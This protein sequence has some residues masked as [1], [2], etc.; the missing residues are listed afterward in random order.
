[1]AAGLL[2]ALAPATPARAGVAAHHVD[3]DRLRF[4]GGRLL[5]A[6]QV[7]SR[8][9]AIDAA[10]AGRA[11]RRL[12]LLR[13]GPAGACTGEAGNFGLDFGFDASAQALAAS[14]LCSGAGA[15]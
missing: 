10:A 14:S 7:G 4:A 3:V 8:S 1:M 12:A 9:E 13:A 11:P 15:P 6:D 2:A 5:L